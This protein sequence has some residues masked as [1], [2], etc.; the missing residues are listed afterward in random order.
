M[1][2][3]KK[4]IKTYMDAKEYIDTIVVPLN[5]FQLSNDND[6]EKITF[7]SEVLTVF[8]QEIEKELTGRILLTPTYHYLKSSSKD[9]EVERIN[10]W[11]KDI[12]KQ[13]FTQ[14][15]FISFD[16][17]WRKYEQA[18]HGELLWL[19]GIHSGDLNS[20][21]MHNVIRDQVEQVVELIRSYWKTSQ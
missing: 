3:T 7:Q 18:L 19:P 15:F 9:N 8:T 2:W 12:Q 17:S 13:N 1:R 21:E 16:S 4:D 6:L 10:T 11:I 14:I 20:K 5:P